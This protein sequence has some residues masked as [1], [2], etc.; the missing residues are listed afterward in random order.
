MSM[1]TCIFLGY[2]SLHCTHMTI[3]VKPSKNMLVLDKWSSVSVA[4]PPQSVEDS[5]IESIEAVDR[6]PPD[7]TCHPAN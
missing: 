6:P 5:V 4:R 2:I 1:Y 7:T 3:Y